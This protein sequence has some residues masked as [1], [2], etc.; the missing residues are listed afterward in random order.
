M[1]GWDSVGALAQGLTKVARPWRGRGLVPQEHLT[2]LGTAVARSRFKV[3][4]P[5]AA[6]V[7][8]A[9][10]GARRITLTLKTALVGGKLPPFTSW[11]VRGCGFGGRGGG[12]GVGVT[13]SRNSRNKTAQPAQAVKRVLQ[14]RAHCARCDSVVSQSVSSTL[15]GLAGTPLRGR[16]HAAALFRH[17]FGGQRCWRM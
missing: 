7:L 3:G 9:D 1:L 11:E 4:Q 15:Q 2:D 16:H 14:G 6:R 8:A 12:G 13:K 17:H 10:A 5:V